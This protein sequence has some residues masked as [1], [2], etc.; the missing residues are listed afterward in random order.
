M[1]NLSKT[2]CIASELVKKKKMLRKS[3]PVKLKLCN[4][5]KIDFNK[6]VYLKYSY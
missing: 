4:I 2:F 1:K 3:L 5:K 6:Q